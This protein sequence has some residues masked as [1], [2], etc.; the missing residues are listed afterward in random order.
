MTQEKEERERHTERARRS[1]REKRGESQRR[2]KQ[3]R[4]KGEGRVHK[5]RGEKRMERERERERDGEKEQERWWR[6]EKP[7]DIFSIIHTIIVE[8]IH[9]TCYQL[10]W[11]SLNSLSLSRSLAVASCY[12][13]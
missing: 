4:R 9:C 6:R 8:W 1:K 13:S 10:F 12:L 3:D 2:K 5:D 7:R 11:R